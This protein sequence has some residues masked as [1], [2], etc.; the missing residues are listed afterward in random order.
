[1]SLTFEHTFQVGDIVRPR[2]G[3]IG[4]AAQKVS[5]G[6]PVSIPGDPTFR[7]VDFV[8]FSDNDVIVVWVGGGDKLIFKSWDLVLVAPEIPQSLGVVGSILTDVSTWKN[9]ADENAISSNLGSD[10]CDDYFDDTAISPDWV[11]FDPAVTMPIPA[12]VKRKI[13]E[14]AKTLSYG[15]PGPS[16]DY[17]PDALRERAKK[18]GATLPTGFEIVEEELVYGFDDIY[19]SHAPPRKG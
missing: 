15:W 14:L 13:R 7:V 1:M 18:E 9:D 19:D 11:P 17:S 5:D 10:R 12:T 2:K 16:R 6:R 3:S 4:V 8:L